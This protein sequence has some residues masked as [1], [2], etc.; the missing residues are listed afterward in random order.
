MDSPSLGQTLS[1]ETRSGRLPAWLHQSFPFVILLLAI[2]YGLA[3]TFW[4]EL[5]TLSVSPS[6]QT[7]SSA[8]GPRITGQIEYLIHPL[9]KVLQDKLWQSQA[10]SR[11]DTGYSGI[12]Y[13]YKPATFRLTLENPASEPATSQVTV[14]APYL[15]HLQPALIHPDGQIERLPAMGD[16]YPFDQRYLAL[17]QWVWPVT[18]QPGTTTL[19]MEVQNRGPVL[20]PVTLSDSAEALGA[21]TAIT[22]WKSFVTGLLVFALLLNLSI[23]AKLRRPGLAWLSVLMIS[24]IYSQLVMDGLGL[25]LI[26]PALPELNALLNISLPLC[27]IALCEFTPHFLQLARTEAR[28]L[29]AFSLLAGA[30]LLAAPLGFQFLGQHAFLMS[31]A[32]G[33]LFIFALS[34]RQ[35]NSHV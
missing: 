14:P 34:L 15:D 12:G 33:G 25:W 7:D 20:L 28:I 19:L 23:V 3:T 16:R 11:T 8:T 30:H 18:L 29:R 22:A 27:L 1:R 5:P 26:W 21:G 35:L 31:S 24:V 13:P 17:P 10:W 9:G 6:V 4:Q 32:I 2:T